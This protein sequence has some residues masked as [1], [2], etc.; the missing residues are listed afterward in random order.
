VG[1]DYVT[2]QCLDIVARDTS[3]RALTSFTRKRKTRC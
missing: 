2:F 1:I 3:T